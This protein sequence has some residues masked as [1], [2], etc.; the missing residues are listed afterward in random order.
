MLLAINE[1]D[2]FRAAS[3]RTPLT[4]NNLQSSW[5]TSAR[6]PPV[7]CVLRSIA[8]NACGVRNGR[9][10]RAPIIRRV[11]EREACPKVISMTHRTNMSPSAISETFSHPNHIDRTATRRVFSTTGQLKCHSNAV[12]P[13]A[14]KGAGRHLVLLT[15]SSVDGPTFTRLVHDARHRYVHR[16]SK[17]LVTSARRAG[18][19]RHSDLRSL[20]GMSNILLTSS[21]LDSA[22]VHG[23]TQR[24]G[25]IVVG[26]VIHNLPSIVPSCEPKFRSTMT[27]LVAL[28]RANIACLANPGTS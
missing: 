25:M 13:L 16:G 22:V 20:G 4:V 23:F 11:S 24:R 12:T 18:V 10:S 5:A 26:H 9:G 14:I 6:T 15:I 21:Q 7:P 1:L 17:L 28:N 3:T 2:D 19:G 27:H 8:E